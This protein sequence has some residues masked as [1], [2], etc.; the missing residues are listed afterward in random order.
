MYDDNLDEYFETF[1]EP[2]NGD[3][4]YDDEGEWFFE[5]GQWWLK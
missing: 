3:K 4:R 5:D 2:S 1:Y